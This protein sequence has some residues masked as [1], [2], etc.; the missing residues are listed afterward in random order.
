MRDPASLFSPFADACPTTLSLLSLP[1]L[2]AALDQDDIGI[3]HFL[4]GRVSKK[5][6]VIQEDYSSRLWAENLVSNIL[7]LVHHQWIAR[8]AVL[9]AR[10]D[11][12]LKIREGQELEAAISRHFQMGT[13]GLLVIDQHLITRGRA[14]VDR[15]TAT[16]QKAWLQNIIIAREIF[17]NTIETE[18]TRMRDYMV[19]WQQDIMNH[20]N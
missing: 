2:E 6:R 16:G 17:E 14:A 8:N 19:R 1:T 4:K 18:T 10:N 13:S 5:W 15:M 11:L 3:R 12:G 20:N 7:T 9:P